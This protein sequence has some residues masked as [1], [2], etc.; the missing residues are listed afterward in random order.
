[1]NAAP[2]PL[3]H[4]VPVAEARAAHAAE[5][6]WLCGQAEEIAALRDVAVPGPGGDVPV[7]IYPPAEPHGVI[8]YLH[9]GG[10]VMGTLDSS[11]VPLARLANAS[12]ATV[13]AVDYR[14]APEHC[15]PAA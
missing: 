4:E 15:F 2:G 8:A 1:M 3:P 11:A 5:T 9:G 7:R 12:G 13:A 14:L 6:E 10:W